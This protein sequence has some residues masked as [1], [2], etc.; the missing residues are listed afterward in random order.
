MAFKII[1]GAGQPWA[2]TRQTR[3]VGSRHT[4]KISGQGKG[5]KGEM[6]KTGCKAQTQEE[7][8]IPLPFGK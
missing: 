7:Q 3:K 5:T 4:E 2:P 1:V 8:L 6:L